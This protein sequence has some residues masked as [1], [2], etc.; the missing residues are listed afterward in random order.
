MMKEYIETVA[1]QM[2]PKDEYKYKKEGDIIII[3]PERSGR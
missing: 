3:I 2:F 1:E